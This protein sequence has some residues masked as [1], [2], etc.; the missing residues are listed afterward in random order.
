MKYFETYLDLFLHPGWKQFVTD[1]EEALKGYDYDSCK[2]YETFLKVKAAREQ[3]LRIV[4]FEE[5]LRFTMEQHAIDVE[6]ENKE[7][8]H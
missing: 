8:V 6:E 4:H 3:L 5:Q 1:T 7:S 2:D